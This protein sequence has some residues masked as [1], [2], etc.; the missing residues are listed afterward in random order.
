MC[1][2]QLNNFKM[3]FDIIIKKMYTVK[4]KKNEQEFAGGIS[5]FLWTHSRWGQ[6]NQRW[7][8]PTDSV[9]PFFFQTLF[10]FLA[11]LRWEQRAVPFSTWPSFRLT[12]EMVYGPFSGW[13]LNE[14]NKSARQLNVTVMYIYSHKVTYSNLTTNKLGL[15]LTFR[16]PTPTVAITRDIR[17]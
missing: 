8:Q 5:L 1:P 14:E 17:K 10:L 13:P 7:P 3:A 2:F 6:G 4:Q 9:S 16:D 11:L 15:F 12:V